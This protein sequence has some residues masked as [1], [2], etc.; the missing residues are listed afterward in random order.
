MPWERIKI[1]RT[2][3]VVENDLEKKIWE[4]YAKDCLT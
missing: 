1:L 2:M 4:V 3:F